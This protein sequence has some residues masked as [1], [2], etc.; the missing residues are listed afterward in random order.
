MFK[1]QPNVM[2]RGS[3]ML[4]FRRLAVKGNKVLSSGKAGHPTPPWQ[5]RSPGNVYRVQA[6]VTYAF[7]HIIA[8]PEPARPTSATSATQLRSDPVLSNRS[9]EQK[10][11]IPPNPLSS[12]SYLRH[13]PISKTPG[14]GRFMQNYRPARHLT[15]QPCIILNTPTGNRNAMQSQRPP[16]NAV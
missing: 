10:R 3:V 9:I 13:A 8:R 15:T 7:G 16:E 1:R 6:L 5:A 12:S 2:T 14:I 4:G 11:K